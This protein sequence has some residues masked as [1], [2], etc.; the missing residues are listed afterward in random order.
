MNH[1]FIDGTPVPEEYQKKVTSLLNQAI[2]AEE[3]FDIDELERFAAE[4][5]RKER[6]DG[7][8]LGALP[9][10]MADCAE[11]SNVKLPIECRAR[12]QAIVDEA[13][14]LKLNFINGNRKDTLER[15]C[16]YDTPAALAILATMMNY[17]SR[18]IR[19][20]FERFFQEVA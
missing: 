5:R 14:V 10:L 13:F 3:K 4:Q 17:V 20:D 16:G 8:T 12:L 15:L 2:E 18:D 1:K 9:I 11:R 19:H 7:I 6:H